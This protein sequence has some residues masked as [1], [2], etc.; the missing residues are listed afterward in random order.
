M[1]LI[2]GHCVRLRGGDFL[3]KTSYSSDP[4]EIARKFE[5]IGFKRLHMVDLDGAKTGSPKHFNVLE[6]VAGQTNLSID[7]SGGI[8]T[9]KDVNIVFE[10]GADYVAIGSMAV[11]NKLLFFKIIE[12]IGAEKIL[13][14]VDVR[15]EQ[16]AI[17]GWLEQT[18]VNVFD[19][20]EEMVNRG[21]T[22]I[23]C[24]DIGRDG[25]MTGP[26]IE[27]YKKIINRFS[28]INLIASG[29]VSDPNQLNDLE[30]IGCMGAIVG[31]AIYED[32]GNLKKWII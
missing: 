14:G 15:N 2:G 11:K 24:T 6:K 28:S 18:N 9:R 30:R 12:E 16:L 8:K 17:A 31:K 5:A 26:S 4:L 25:M 20:L 29:G 13:L 1:D 3:Q 10:K 22:N 19:F 27:L 32:N 21:V 7:F 23:F